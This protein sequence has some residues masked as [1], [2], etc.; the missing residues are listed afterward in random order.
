MQGDRSLERTRGGLGV[1]LTLVRSLV[2][3]HGGSVEARS[4]GPGTGSEF[5]VTL[6]LDPAKQPAAPRR[7]AADATE[8][9]SAGVSSSPTTTPTPAR[10]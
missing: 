9:G 7:D 5:V 2:L 10:C 4:D 8:P 3:L 1:G 6:P